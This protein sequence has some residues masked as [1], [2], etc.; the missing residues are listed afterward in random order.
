M[1]AQA[2]PELLALIGKNEKILWQGRPD[3]RCFLLEA[4]FNPLLPLALIWGLLDA[5]FISLAL[6][7]ENF[8]KEMSVFMIG[9]FA[10]HLM[11]VWIYLAGVIFSI[12]RYQNTSFAITDQGVYVSGGLLTQNYERKPFAEMSHVNLSRGLFDRWIGVG[13]VVMSNAHETYHHAR[14][15]IFK[16]TSICD[17]SDYAEVYQL[18]KKLQTDIFTDAMY[19]NDMRP[20]TNR[21]YHTRYDTNDMFK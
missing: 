7:Q 3:K 4:V 5:S 11:P 12:F 17:I 13:D 21:G 6:H 10:L 9:F 19:P 8:P 15:P 2:N 18:V 1:Q 16:G 14:M 20:D